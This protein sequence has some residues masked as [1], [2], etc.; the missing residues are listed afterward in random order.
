M[1][2]K[3]RELVIADVRDL[4]R[5]IVDIEGEG[6]VQVG[7]VIVTDVGDSGGEIVDN[8]VEVGEVVG[9]DPGCD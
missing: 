2:I 1:S 5:E 4:W 7:E 9:A 8:K 3:G 6:S